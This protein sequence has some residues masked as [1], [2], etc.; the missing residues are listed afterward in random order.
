MDCA[1]LACK[2][3]YADG[4]NTEGMINSI[5]DHAM[6]RNPRSGAFPYGR[7]AGDGHDEIVAFDGERASGRIFDINCLA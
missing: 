1:D 2:V 7:P 6:R 3:R 4:P 5:L